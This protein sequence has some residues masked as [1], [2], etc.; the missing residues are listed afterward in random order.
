MPSKINVVAIAFV[1]AYVCLFVF[2]QIVVDF[3][4]CLVGER[5][6][7]LP[8]FESKPIPL[9]ECVVEQNQD[10]YR[11][12]PE[13]PPQN[14]FCQV[15]RDVVAGE[16]RAPASA[17]IGII[18]YRENDS[19]GDGDGNGYCPPCPLEHLAACVEACDGFSA[20]IVDGG[21]VLVPDPT[22]WQE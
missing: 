14:G 3:I 11:C 12:G 1:N 7:K 15:A 21:C 20:L 8:L 18:A 10:Y 19:P 6:R 4:V 16:D 17:T 9:S 2:V 5:L 13:D 22:S